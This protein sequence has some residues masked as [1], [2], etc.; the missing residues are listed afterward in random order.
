MLVALCLVWI[1]LSKL[2]FFSQVKPRTA[3]QIQQQHLPSA[4]HRPHTHVHHPL[5]FLCP[6]SRSGGRLSRSPQAKTTAKRSCRLHRYLHLPHKLRVNLSSSPLAGL[7]T[8]LSL[9]HQPSQLVPL[10]ASNCSPLPLNQVKAMPSLCPHLDETK[11]L[12]SPKRDHLF[13]LRPPLSKLLGNGVQA[14][15]PRNLPPLLLWCAALC[16]TCHW[17]MPLCAG[18]PLRRP[19]LHLLSTNGPEAGLEQPA[20]LLLPVTS[21][22]RKT[23]RRKVNR[24]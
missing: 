11:I 5:L 4:L 9:L 3:R 24:G 7:Q 14:K 6:L 10:R 13:L 22:E 8:P 20:C 19:H 15:T 16:R 18:W 2:F 17:T 12:M 21:S 23:M 1:S